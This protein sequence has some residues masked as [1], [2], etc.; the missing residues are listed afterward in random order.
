MKNSIQGALKGKEKRFFTVSLAIGACVLWATTNGNNVTS[1][2]NN[3]RNLNNRPSVASVALVTLP[4]HQ[5]QL[6]ARQESATPSPK[7]IPSEP[8][9]QVATGDQSANLKDIHGSL[10]LRY[11]SPDG[12]KL[13]QKQSNS[14]ARTVLAGG[15]N[16]Q[17]LQVSTGPKSLNI[18]GVD[19]DVEID[20][21]AP[22]TTAD[23]KD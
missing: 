21:D 23:N 15:A 18:S 19:K 16:L 9:I 10:H 17:S 11:N 12:Q 13:S 4:A 7:A 20:F 1:I 3:V 6:P 2:L 5:N 8:V 14:E 22:R